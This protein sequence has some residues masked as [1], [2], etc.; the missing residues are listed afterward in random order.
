MIIAMLL[1]LPGFLSL[2]FWLL[3]AI[4]ITLKDYFVSA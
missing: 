3:R 4:S 1:I 2:L